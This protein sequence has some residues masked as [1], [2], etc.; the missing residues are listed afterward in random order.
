[1]IKFAQPAT[2]NPARRMAE[3]LLGYTPYGSDKTASRYGRMAENL[4]A[5]GASTEPTGHWMQAAARGVQGVVGGYYGALADRESELADQRQAQAAFAKEQRDADAELAKEGRSHDNALAIAREKALIEQSAPAY[6]AGLAKTAA[7]TADLTAKE[8]YRQLLMGLVVGDGTDTA[9]HDALNVGGPPKDDP[10]APIPESLPPAAGMPTSPT[11]AAPTGTPPGPLPGG[12][13]QPQP[14]VQPQSFDGGARPAQLENAST[15]SPDDRRRRM[16]ETLVQADGGVPPG[17][18]PPSPQPMPGVQFVSDAAPSPAGPQPRPAPQ[19]NGDMIDTPMGRMTRD[20]A[21]RIGGAML[22]D[23][24]SAQYGKHLLDQASATAAPGLSQPTINALQEKQLN[25]TEA[26]SRLKSI[27]QAYKPEYQ[28]IE[29]RIGN[30]W[31]ELVDSFSGT[32]QSLTPEQKTQLADFSAYRADALNNLNQYIKEITGAAMTN[33]EAERIMRAMP[34]PGDGVFNGDSPTVFKAKL[35]AAIR[36][37]KMALAR[38]HY[39]SK[40]GFSGSVDDM[41]KHLSLDQMGGVIQNRTNQLLQESLSQNPGL[42]P[43]D[44]API[45]RQRLRAEFGIDA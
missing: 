25:T 43:Q 17:A 33:A 12:M 30:K 27:E 32:R 8:R 23:P 31:A 5:A 1:M 41:A 37:S 45:I 38:Y 22:M 11:P 24:M 26:Y 34:N 7:E 44:V 10:G 36:S 6:R 39:L 15:V 20:R 28:T 29:T 4:M 42:T 18:M 2:E 35:D 13:P 3:R 14:G 9:S 21:R 40:N 19:P 16:A